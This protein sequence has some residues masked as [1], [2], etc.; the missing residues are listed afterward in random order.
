[1]MSERDEIKNMVLDLV[2]E[3]F[4][5]SVPAGFKLDVVNLDRGEKGGIVYLDGAL[6]RRGSELLDGYHRVMAARIVGASESLKV[7]VVQLEDD[8][9]DPVPGAIYVP[10][11]PTPDYLIDRP[12]HTILIGWSRGDREATRD[13][14]RT[15]TM[16]GLA[17]LF[18]N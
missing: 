5:H 13:E 17:D 15:A 8:V 14:L 7:R 4:D 6:V 16:A 3:R 18:G 2:R 10:A 11:G 1:M 9:E 12:S